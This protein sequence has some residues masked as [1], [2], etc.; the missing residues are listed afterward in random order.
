MESSINI[1][2]ISQLAMGDCLTLESLEGTFPNLELDPVDAFL[3]QVNNLEGV[4]YR[5]PTRPAQGP[6]EVLG[7]VGMAASFKDHEDHEMGQQNIQNQKAME[8]WCA[9][10]G[11]STRDRIKFGTWALYGSN[12]YINHIQ[13]PKTAGFI[14]QRNLINFWW[15]H[16]CDPYPNGTWPAIGEIIQSV[17]VYIYMILYMY[18]NIYIYI[19]YYI[20]MWTYIYIYIN[21]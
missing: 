10:S 12:N 5:L 17:C 20:C 19:W 13:P 3:C 6:D 1:K 14:L 21:L 16:K 7:D 2:A 9:T 4:D 15:A 8:I 18:V 11:D